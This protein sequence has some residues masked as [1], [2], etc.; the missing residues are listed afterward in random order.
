MYTPG[1]SSEAANRAA[2]LARAAP[3]SVG[4]REKR[5]DAKGGKNDPGCKQKQIL[6]KRGAEGVNS[7]HEDSLPGTSSLFVLVAFKHVCVFVCVCV[8]VCA[9]VCECVCVCACEAMRLSQSSHVCTSNE[10]QCTMRTLNT[11]TNTKKHIHRPG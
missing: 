6:Y 5:S 11:K 3:I 10:S 2:R 8:C 1:S 9:R 7:F 4:R